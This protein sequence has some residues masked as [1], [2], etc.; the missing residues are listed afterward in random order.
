M[1]E[2]SDT[3]M[4]VDVHGRGEGPDD[5]RSHIKNAETHTEQDPRTAKDHIG[6]QSTAQYRDT[7]NFCY[8][9][10]GNLQGN[11]QDVQVEPMMKDQES[12][13]VAEVKNASQKL[14][15]TSAASA[16]KPRISSS[17]PKLASFATNALTSA[18]AHTSFSRLGSA[19]FPPTLSTS[20]S[21][22]EI[23]ERLAEARR[24]DPKMVSGPS[25]FSNVVGAHSRPFPSLTLGKDPF[26]TAGGS[27]I[28]T[29]SAANT[30]G[31]GA[32]GGSD[33]NH[34][35]AAG[36]VTTGGYTGIAGAG[37]G[38][39]GNST[40]SNVASQLTSFLSD[41]L[42]EE[43]RRT[44]TRYVPV[45]PGMHALRKHEI[46]GD[47]NLVR[48]QLPSALLGKS[49]AVGG[50]AL[51]TSSHGSTSTRRKPPPVSLIASNDDSVEVGRESG[52]AAKVASAPAGADDDRLSDS[53]MRNV[54]GN[55]SSSAGSNT[56]VTIDLGLMGIVVP[57]TAFVASSAE[58]GNEAIEKNTSVPSAASGSGVSSNATS[59]PI[60]S[61]MGNSS[62]PATAK[63][64]IET[65]SPRH[66]E[67]V[68]AFNPPRPPESV[69][70][71]KRHRMLRWERRPADIEVDLASYRKTVHQTRQ[72]LKNTQAQMERLETIDNHLRKSYLSHLQHLDLEWHQLHRQVMRAQEECILAA[73][74]PLT[75]T[76]SRGVGKGSQ[77]IADVLGVVKE[78]GAAIID[79]SLK[80]GQQLESRK[81]VVGL[82][83]VGC[84]N[85]VEPVSLATNRPVLLPDAW[86]TPGDRMETPFGVGTVLAVYGLEKLDL[87]CPPFPGLF[88]KR[89][90]L[91]PENVEQRKILTED[92]EMIHSTASSPSTRP[93]NVPKS[94]SG[95]KV[96]S[97]GKR[98]RKGVACE[99]DK[100][101]DGENADNFALQCLLQPRVLV[102]LPF[103]VA[104]FQP[105]V[106]SSLESPS[107]YSD[108]RLALRWKGI[109]DSADAFGSIIDVGALAGTVESQSVSATE[110]KVSEADASHNLFVE[111][112]SRLVPF[113]ASVFPTGGPRGGLLSSVPLSVLERE[114]DGALYRGGG[115][116]GN[117]D[118]E[119][120]PSKWKEKEAIQQEYIDL[121]ANVL[122]LRN[123]LFRQ[124]RTRILNERTY[125]ATRERSIRA[126]TLVAE[127]RSD[128]KS[129]RARLDEEVRELGMTAED[130]EIILSAFYKKMDANGT[131]KLLPK[132]RNRQLSEAEND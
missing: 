24:G 31:T 79:R 42:T 112:R 118:N 52:D 13:D 54:S 92:S 126:E 14:Q 123:Q 80:Y 68:T 50:I 88:S 37:S 27:T 57:S 110:E 130:A 45:V 114:L 48:S 98:K 129:L 43:E 63:K 15:A 106:L 40:A 5:A 67:T 4:L 97:T 121:R 117:V 44:R 81:P 93:E 17:A 107:S 104:Y 38:T 19:A 9:G 33:G 116:L 111:R 30:A 73:D 64:M 26:A 108:A 131:S 77:I 18:S 91:L 51:S 103:G 7:D 87:K 83:G 34:G 21:A 55:S 56:R 115:I 86:V 66:V 89:S 109:L 122:H 65:R 78:R 2:E 94:S 96:A 62:F 32:V 6:S 10:T 75:R 85:F 128:L 53:I 39:T 16:S 127:M 132:T 58:S 76:R 47:L 120:V 46:K 1:D 105:G 8:Q 90:Q 113:G 82:G 102:R 74:L 125:S 25:A 41:S 49:S 84:Q 60:T 69:G 29:L 36:S 95:S 20:L 71:K 61:T 3:S 59:V 35:A 119:G 28:S 124:R 22:S 11:I 70:A 72:E 12:M 100:K 101:I 23:L 99:K